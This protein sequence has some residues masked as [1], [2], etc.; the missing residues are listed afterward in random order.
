M[1]KNIVL[2]SLLDVSKALVIAVSEFQ[3]VCFSLSE[4]R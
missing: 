1:E 3:I 4:S 2:I